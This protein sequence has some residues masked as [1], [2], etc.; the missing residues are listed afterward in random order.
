MKRPAAALAP[1]AELGTGGD[2]AVGFRVGATV[3]V[4]DLKSA[5][6]LNGKT[7]KLVRSDTSSWRWQ[8]GLEERL[9]TKALKSAN[10][11]IAEAELG[12]GRDGA[13]GFRLGASVFIDGVD[14]GW[15][16]KLDFF[17]G[18][19][20]HPDFCVRRE[21]LAIEGFVRN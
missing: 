7:G 6:Q 20:G 10:L 18:V 8:V 17:Y 14:G 12:S 13:V 19:V 9:G 2:S 1:E 21:A 15:A 4:D 11:T 16:T 5:P 3:I